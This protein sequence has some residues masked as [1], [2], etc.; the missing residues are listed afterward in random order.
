MVV[1]ATVVLSSQPQT[2]RRRTSTVC[3]NA[4]KLHRGVDYPAWMP[5]SSVFDGAEAADRL[6]EACVALLDV[7]AATISL[8]FDGTSGGNLGPWTQ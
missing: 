2:G 7:D 6:C 4:A 8:A 1:G 5:K 3:T